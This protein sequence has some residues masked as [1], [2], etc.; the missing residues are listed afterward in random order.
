[1]AKKDNSM[2]ELCGPRPWP[3]S[4]RVYAGPH[5]RLL[6]LG[7]SGKPAVRVHGASALPARPRE[8]PAV[9]ATT[10][11]EVIAL[12]AALAVG[13]WL[14]LA[15]SWREARGAALGFA[16]GNLLLTAGVGLTLGRAE[17]L[18]PHASPPPSGWPLSLWLPPSLHFWLHFWLADLMA[19][20]AL[21]T[22]RASALRLH[23]RPVPR[24]ELLLVLGLA[25][26]GLALLE[27]ASLGARAALFG[28]AA[29]WLCLRMVGETWRQLRRRPERLAAL[30]TAAVFGSVALSMGGRA[31]ALLL[32]PDWALPAE[33]TAVGASV[34][35]LWS[36]LLQLMLINLALAALLL[37]RLL[38]RIRHLALHDPLTGCLNRR[39]LDAQLAHLSLRG[40]YAAVLL[41][42]DHFKRVNDEHGHVAGDAALLHLVR[43]LRADL[44][45]VDLIGRWGGEEFLLLLPDAGLS[46]AQLVAERLRSALESTPLRW[47]GHSVPITASFAVAAYGRCAVDFALLDASLLRAKAQGRNC[48]VSVAA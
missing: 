1:V 22:L 39:A 10:L 35:L 28:L 47:Q 12:V 21:A 13:G 18:A 43:L 8:G 29:V 9:I 3:G 45:E 14:L 4:Q 19:L 30:V 7:I 36:V 15:W 32:R 48:V 41:D 20:G 2:G 5:V 16:L 25:A 40:S 37:T 27:P 11:A 34:P 46:D 23:E 33:S 26:L 44:R 42:I 31:L 17:A 38:A 6:H 24:L